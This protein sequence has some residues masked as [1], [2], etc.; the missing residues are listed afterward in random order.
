MKDSNGKKSKNAFTIKD[1]EEKEM[2]L[3]NSEIS[4]EI[5]ED[6]T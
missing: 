3:N 1:E 6:V 5:I 2:Q 4:N